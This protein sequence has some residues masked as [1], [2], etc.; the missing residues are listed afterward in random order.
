MRQYT[1][2]TSHKV[3]RMLKVAAAKQKVMNTYSPETA[4]DAVWWRTLVLTSATMLSI[5]GIALL[6]RQ[7]ASQSL[8]NMSGLRLSVNSAGKGLLRML[9][10]ALPIYAGMIIG[11]TIVALALG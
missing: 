9:S 2:P 3:W 6:R 11:G 4:V 1:A 5:G 10:L 8:P 7:S